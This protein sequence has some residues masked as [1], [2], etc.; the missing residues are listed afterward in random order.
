MAI[1]FQITGN[2]VYPHPDTLLISPF[3]EI[4]EKDETPDKKVALAEFAYIEF[5]TS[6]LNTNPYK[7][8]TNVER[9]SKVK[10]AV[11]FMPKWRPS[12]LI[13][14]AT[15]LMKKF[16]EE[17]SP[18]YSYYI[19]ARKAIEKMKR[20]F[21]E[22]DINARNEKGALL[23]KPRDITSAITDTEKILT[24]MKSLEVKVHEE[25]YDVIKTKAD[26]DISPF[27]DPESL[28]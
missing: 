17:A 7:G 23:Y 8:Y 11:I 13:E 5:T 2:K 19:S 25:V 27:A 16:Q 20:F 12:K 4:W 1:L 10:A 18:T 15:L 24:T 21:E 26:K 28:M 9:P 14:E 6:M 3:K 22:V